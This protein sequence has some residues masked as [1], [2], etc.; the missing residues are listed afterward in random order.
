MTRICV[1]VF[2]AALSLIAAAVLFVYVMFA[3]GGDASAVAGFFLLMNAV[4][5]GLVYMAYEDG[6]KGRPRA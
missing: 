3:I 6:K 2:A 1:P 5:Y 4:Q